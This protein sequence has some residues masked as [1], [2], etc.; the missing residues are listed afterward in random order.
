LQP[1]ADTA[2]GQT[3]L[4]IEGQGHLQAV[5]TL[6]VNIAQELKPDWVIQGS[7]TDVPHASI[8]LRLR[9]VSSRLEGGASVQTIFDVKET[10]TPLR[11]GD[12]LLLA[13]SPAVAPALSVPLPAVLPRSNGNSAIVFV[14][15]PK[16]GVVTRRDVVLGMIEG[17]RVQIRSGLT[18]GEQIVIAGAAFLSDGQKVLPFRSNSRLSTGGR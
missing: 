16:S 2:P 13:L 9:S 7:R 11:S 12:T 17:E 4:Q 1:Q 6:P 8:T 10:T 5:A 15:Q 3:V 18:L 14:Y